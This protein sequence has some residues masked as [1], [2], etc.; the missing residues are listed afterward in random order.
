MVWAKQVDR[1]E[2]SEIS[3][4]KF[5]NLINCRFMMIILICFLSPFTGLILNEF[6]TLQFIL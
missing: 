1:D 4:G 6:I 3:T 2:E 5:Y